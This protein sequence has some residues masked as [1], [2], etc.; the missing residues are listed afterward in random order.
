[1]KLFPRVV[2]LNFH[3]GSRIVTGEPERI[4]VLW[5][6]CI[7]CCFL[8]WST[9]LVVYPVHLCGYRCCPDKMSSLHC[10]TVTNLN[11]HFCH[12]PLWI[13]HHLCLHHPLGTIS[14]TDTVRTVASR[15][16]TVGWVIKYLSSQWVEKLSAASLRTDSWLKMSVKG[17]AI[18]IHHER[19]SEGRK[20]KTNL[21]S[22]Q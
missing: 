17:R 4:S 21:A 6:C 7:W 22:A 13:L 1:M 10:F 16:T 5:W 19:C 11:F 3:C 2:I 12:K 15:D 18:K 20:V 14:L 8:N 9:Q